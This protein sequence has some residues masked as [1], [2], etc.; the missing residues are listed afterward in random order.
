MMPVDLSIKRV[1]EKMAKRLR[2]RAAHNHRSLQG[3]LMAILH[4]AVGD[5]SKPGATRPETRGRQSVPPHSGPTGWI[6]APRSESALM[7]REDREG[8]TFTIEDL[9][10]YVSGLGQGTPDE[11]TQ[12]IRQ[13]RTSR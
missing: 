13:G 8:R 5:P 9:R 7:I 2:E 1:P 4:E 3:E 12:W 10:R 6:I 11:S